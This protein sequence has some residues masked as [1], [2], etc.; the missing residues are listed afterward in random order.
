VLEK[1]IGPI[2]HL[3]RN[4]II[5]GL[6]DRAG[7]LAAGKPEIGEVTLALSQQGNEIAIELADDGIGL[8][9]GR[10]R[11]KALELGLLAADASPDAEE[12]TEL[13]FVPGFSTAAEL[14]EMA[15]RGVGMDVVKSEVSALGGRI[16]V[17]SQAGAGTRFHLYLPLTLTISHSV[18]VRVASRTHALPA[19]MVE[20]VQQLKPAAIERI[21]A[22][23]GTEWLGRRYPWHYL[24]RL[25]GDETSQPAP[26]RRHC[27]LLLKG[28]GQHIA[29]EVDEL[30]GNQ[31]IVV[32]NIGPQLARVIGIT[33]ATVLG[34]GEIALIINPI[35]LAG[36]KAQA[37]AGRPAA[38]AAPLSRAR[39][40]MVVDDSLTVRK[41]TGRLLA[42]EGYQVI[43]AK[44]GVDALEQMIDIL[45]DALILDI[46]MPRMDGFDLTR[47]LRADARLRGIPIIMVTSRTADKHRDYARSLGVQHYLG[48]PYDEEELLRA[49]SGVLRQAVPA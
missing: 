48:K 9:Y 46:E 31:E 34:D 12:L 49:L 38:P 18:L 21:R 2:E 40:V 42:R 10:I 19:G 39:T 47:N 20:Q 1:I 33:G 14:T 16:T 32:K 4:A 24:P 41:V 7:R 3:L 43:S 29:L 22:D 35:A 30:I 13:I 28:A 45:P 27:L 15:G 26:A 11:A 6:E 44:D 36:R 23:G 25:L 17:S 37:G 8:D 5:H